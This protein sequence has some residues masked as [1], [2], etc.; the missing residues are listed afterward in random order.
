MKSPPFSRCLQASSL[1]LT[2]AEEVEKIQ[3]LDQVDGFDY[4]GILITEWSLCLL[5]KVVLGISV[6]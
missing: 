3:R 4:M 1:K 5:L 2:Q 6:T